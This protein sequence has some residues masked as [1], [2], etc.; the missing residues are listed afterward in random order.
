MLVLSAQEMI[1]RGGSRRLL[2]TLPELMLP[3]AM[4]LQDGNIRNTALSSKAAVGQGAATGPC[5]QLLKLERSSACCV[6]RLPLS[7]W[8]AFTSTASSLPCR[9]V[10]RHSHSEPTY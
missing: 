10:R 8:S 4:P 1:A 2:H 3:T 6:S 7:S 5:S 9:F